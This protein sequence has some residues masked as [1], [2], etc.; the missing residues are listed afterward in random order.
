MYMMDLPLFKTLEVLSLPDRLLKSV[1]LPLSCIGLNGQNASNIMITQF[2]CACFS[3]AS[4]NKLYR[5]KK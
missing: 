3:I 4:Q 2:S 5:N 1:G